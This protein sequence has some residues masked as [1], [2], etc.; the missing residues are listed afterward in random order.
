MKPLLPKLT[1][2]DDDRLRE[3]CYRKLADLGLE[4]NDRYVTQ[5]DYEL[6]VFRKVGFAGYML[7]VADF[8]SWARSQQIPVGPGR[9]SAAG[10]LVAYTLGI[11]AIDPLEHG[12]FFERFLNPERVSLCDIDTDFCE[13][14][15]DEVVQYCI[16]RYG[17]ERVAN[18]GT[19]G[20]MRGRAAV[21]DVCRALAIPA[22]EA[23][24]VA[25]MIPEPR[26]GFYLSIDEAIAA[27]GSLQAY[28]EGEGKDVMRIARS[29]EGMARHPSTH[30]AGIIIADR[31][32]RD[33]VPLWQ[34]KD[35]RTVTAWDM[36]AVEKAGLV[37]FDFLGLK[38]LSVLSL[39][40]K[41]A[42]I[43]TDLD[44]LPL[45]LP[46]VYQ[47]ISTGHTVGLFQLESSG[48]QQLV[49]RQ[50]PDKFSDLVALLALY[51]P[52]PLEGGV[53]DSFVRR[54][55]G[56]EAV[57]HPHPAAEDILRETYGI[58]VYQE[59]AMALARAIAGYS[60]AEADSLRKAIGKKNPEEMAKHR[61]RW[62]GNEALFNKIEEFAKYSFAKAHS[63]AY[64]MITYQTAWAKLNHPR[65]FM[66][67]LMTYDQTHPNKLRKAINEAVRM[68]IRILPPDVNESGPDFTPTGEGIRFGLNALKR[69]GKET[70]DRLI[71]LRPIRN[72]FQL[73]EGG[74]PQGVLTTLA[75]AGALDSLTPPGSTR[76]DVV[77]YIPHAIKELKRKRKKHPVI[78]TGKRWTNQ[79]MLLKEH[80]AT[81][82]YF[83]GHPL[84]SV[85]YP[86]RVMID[87][88]SDTPHGSYCDIVALAS[89][90]SVK[91]T[92]R[93][94]KYGKLVLEDESGVVEGLAW[95]TTWARVGYIIQ[96]GSPLLLRVKVEHQ[97]ELTSVF[98]EGA[99]DFYCVQSQHLRR[100][101][102]NATPQTNW[103]KVREIADR[104]PGE[105]PLVAM[106]RNGQL[107]ATITLGVRVQPHP[108]LLDALEEL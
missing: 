99:A 100:I 90:V 6:D 30:A 71:S 78:E 59:Q 102:F 19:F 89:Q 95:P 57:D 53:V 101:E 63:A 7:I 67:A 77:E 47:A 91:A 66:A 20:S 24:K 65:E 75:E 5:L 51:R 35:G 62:A 92:K 106:V 49:A 32:I 48:M 26:Q 54:K 58:I 103:G 79:E 74:I 2:N 13:T 93:G 43:T 28:A 16:S 15:R 34:D 105:L 33:V 8:I 70:V 46:D 83:S 44:A 39:T 36:K 60:L 69:V 87:K 45:D 94:E 31:N 52:G 96:S 23:Q 88:L 82:H 25:N 50:V 41:L 27:D 10:S 86:L 68:G 56:E 81:G 108:D 38:T 64:A 18:I 97:E 3:L 40:K 21:K 22:S 73:A 104:F 12:L 55:R 9:G 76:A 14:R 17:K 61:S 107:D 85:R 4:F 98:V 84:S 37:K 29:I 72:I 11:T 1:D 80:N 42:G